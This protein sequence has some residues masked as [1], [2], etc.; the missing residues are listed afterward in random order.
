MELINKSSRPLSCA[1]GWPKGGCG[2]RANARGSGTECPMDSVPD[3]LASAGQN[4]GKPIKG[5]PS[6]AAICSATVIRP[7]VTAKASSWLR[8]ILHPNQSEYEDSGHPRAT[9]PVIDG[10]CNTTP[11]DHR[12]G[13]IQILRVHR[14][15]GEFF[16]PIFPPRLPEW[17]A[18]TVVPAW[19]AVALSGLACTP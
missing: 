12:P 1:Q 8:H 10:N 4:T 3:P 13:P 11:E 17:A 6:A 16:L 7:T 2:V 9:R 5:P 14:A 19:R 18:A 15:L